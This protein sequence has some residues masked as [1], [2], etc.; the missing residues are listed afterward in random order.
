[1][2]YLLNYIGSIIFMLAMVLVVIGIIFLDYFIMRIV[3]EPGHPFYIRLIYVFLFIL[4]V[5]FST[6]LLLIVDHLLKKISK[7]NTGDRKD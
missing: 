2:K 3:P 5:L 1:M 6:V 7:G 4:Y